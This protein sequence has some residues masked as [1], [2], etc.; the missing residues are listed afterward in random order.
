MRAG[1]RLSPRH[2][3]RRQLRSLHRGRPLPQ[4]AR[5]REHSS[6]DPLPSGSPAAYLSVDDAHGAFDQATSGPMTITFKSD[7]PD[8]TFTNQ[9]APSG[10]NGDT[11]TVT[12]NVNSYS[13]NGFDVITLG[14][15]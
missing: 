3:G 7:N 12:A 9:S 1:A 15:P 4:R 14:N 13:S 5:H 2:A 11:I 10:V 8:I 6:T